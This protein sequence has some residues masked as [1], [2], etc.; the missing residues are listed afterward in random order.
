MLNPE[1]PIVRVAVFGKQ[2][3]D[4]VSSDIGRFI[5]RRA[6]EEVTDCLQQ[7]KSISPAMPWGRR[8]IARLQNQIATAERVI[9]WLAEAIHEGHQAMNV[10]EDKH[11]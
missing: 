9:H 6:D 7:L 2:A 4:F 1:D 8:K 11:E 10:I 5:T 3:E